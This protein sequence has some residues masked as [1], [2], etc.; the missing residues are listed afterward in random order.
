MQKYDASPKPTLQ[1]LRMNIHLFR[2]LHL[3]SSYFK[4]IRKKGNMI[5][6]EKIHYLVDNM[7]FCMQV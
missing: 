1:E 6:A 2:F 4:N 7:Y 3:C 5:F